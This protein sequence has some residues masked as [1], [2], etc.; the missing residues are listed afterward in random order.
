MRLTSYSLLVLII[1]MF[2]LSAWSAS[3]DESEA[4]VAK[5]EALFESEWERSMR[6]HP[7][8]ASFLGDRR[9]NDQLADM[10]LVAIKARH[11]QDIEAL[12]RLRAIDRAALPPDSQLN[13]DLFERNLQGA[14]AGF[15]Y[16]SYLM[17][18]NQRGGVQT[19]QQIPQRLRLTTA[20]SYRDWIARLNAFD[21]YIGQT[22]ALMQK[23]IE[24][25]VV[26]PEVVMQ[27]IPD[28]LALHV[29]DTAQESPFF[30]AF[31]QR[32]EAISVEEWKTIKTAGVKAIE[33]V[34][35][36]AY[37]E[38]QDFFLD[39]YLPKSRQ[40]VGAWDL[41]HGREYY[42][43]LAKQFTTTNLTPKEIHQIGLKEVARIKGEMKAIIEEVGFEGSFA[44]FLD[45]LRTDPK[46]FYESKDELFKSYKAIAKSIDPQLV[47]L[48]GHLPRIP[49]GVR[50][51]PAAIAPDTTTAYYMPPAADGSRA[52]FY[53][54]NLYKPEA[55]PKWEMD[56]LTVHEAVPGHHL[57]ISIAQELKDL[58]KF[59]RYGGETAFVEGW[60][61][62]S[63]SLCQEVGL[64]DTPYT[65]F[66]Q[67]TYDMWRAVRLVVDTGIHSMKWSR[68]KAIEYFMANAP[69]TKQDVV[70]EIDR[71]IAWPG[72]ALAYKIGQL[73]IL[74]L[75]A[76]AQEALGTEFNVKAFHDTVLKNGAVPLDVLER[77]VED[78]IAE[79]DSR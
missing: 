76:Q 18:V 67:L 21:T 3:T 36:P 16:Q 69:K 7:L 50:K 47:H 79:Q 42:E 11:Q 58:P 64:C 46:F 77:I 14:I 1:W 13:Y 41:P 10:S 62:Y 51:I 2:S 23:G 63:E 55:R 78:W 12:Q 44:E 29:V 45:Y 66:G 49:Y 71:Y 31:K 19:A 43:Y 38:F 26:M 75:K 37:V 9:F 56:V 68:E 74:E 5:L 61:L 6:Q 65:R 53:Y 48:F 32:P 34:I 28:Q 52:G 60:A 70:N 17:P 20:D 59:R 57:Q 22:I 72:Q 30:K 54:V 33:D 4:A 35:L 39:T 40:T 15:K 27:R 8:W 25:G 73:K 24:E